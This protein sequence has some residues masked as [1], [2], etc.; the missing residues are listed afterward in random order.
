[1]QAI[2]R[3]RHALV[4]KWSAD[5]LHLLA[6]KADALLVVFRC[7]LPKSARLYIGIKGRTCLAILTRNSRGM[8]KRPGM[9]ALRFC[10][11]RAS[12]DS[13]SVGGLASWCRFER[14]WCDVCASLCLCCKSCVAVVRN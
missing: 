11:R 8:V 1:M 13:V 5:E 9:M 2:L 12:K 3:Q 14:V 7:Q 4:K 10:V 6:H